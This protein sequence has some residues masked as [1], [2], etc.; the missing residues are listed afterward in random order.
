MKKKTVGIH[1]RRPPAQP[2]KSSKSPEITKGVDY[3]VNC[4]A[5]DKIAGNHLQSYKI[6]ECD[7]RVKVIRK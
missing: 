6:G 4:S 7:A 3:V 1:F 5:S 2:T